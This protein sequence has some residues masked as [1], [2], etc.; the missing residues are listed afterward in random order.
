MKRTTYILIG[1]IVVLFLFSLAV[2]LYIAST[3]IER[4]SGLG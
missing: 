1:M 3:G 4:V 2:L